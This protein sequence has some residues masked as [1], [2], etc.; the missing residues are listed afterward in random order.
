MDNKVTYTAESCH[1][2][3][4]HLFVFLT[5]AFVVTAFPVVATHHARFVVATRRVMAALVCAGSGGRMPHSHV[6]SSVVVTIRDQI[7]EGR[8]G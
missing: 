1:F 2:L 4:L 7:P 8:N 3:L 6:G 5:T